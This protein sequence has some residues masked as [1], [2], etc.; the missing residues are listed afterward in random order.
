[1]APLHERFPAITVRFDR[2]V[3]PATKHIPQCLRP[4]IN[5]LPT[6]SHLPNNGMIKLLFKP[7]I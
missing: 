6:R 1:M 3:V 4:G 7:N 5:Q 2:T